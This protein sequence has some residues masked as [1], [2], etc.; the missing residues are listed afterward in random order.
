MQTDHPLHSTI[1]LHIADDGVIR[2]LNVPP[3]IKD[4]SV[5]LVRDRFMASLLSQAIVHG[6]VHGDPH[7]GNWGLLG[8]GETIVMLDFGKMIDLQKK[9][10]MAPLML[11][12]AWFR[13]D[14]GGMAD[15][16]L[17]MTTEMKAGGDKKAAKK[18][19]EASLKELASKGDPAGKP[20]P[21]LDGKKHKEPRAEPD[22]II[23]TITSTL[24]THGLG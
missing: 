21:P 15:A 3:I 2:H 14:A 1:E 13:R 5:R 11:A 10:L 4:D 22:E 9:H 17:T 6:R 18:A 24:A 23:A 19:L 7:K 16:V 8:D 12:W 20:P